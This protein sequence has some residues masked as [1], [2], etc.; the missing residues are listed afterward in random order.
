MIEDRDRASPVNEE[1]IGRIQGTRVIFASS[2]RLL[3]TRIT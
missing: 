1:A 2:D 3:S